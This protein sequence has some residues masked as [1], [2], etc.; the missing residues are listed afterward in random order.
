MEKLCVVKTVETNAQKFIKILLVVMSIVFVICALLFGIGLLVIP[1][2]VLFV[3]YLVNFYHAEIS[4]DY[5][6]F[7][8]EMKIARIKGDNRRKLLY[9]INLDEAKMITKADDP[10]LY[11]VENQPGVI[12]KDFSSHMGEK[13]LYK[14]VFSEKEKT[15]VLTIEPSEDFLDAL[16]DKYKRIIT[17]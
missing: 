10:S 13:Q 15:Y 12:K 5:T 4:Y 1:A 6:Y 3:L 17:R 14:V 16:C 2:I 8:N 9:T 7:G 11:N